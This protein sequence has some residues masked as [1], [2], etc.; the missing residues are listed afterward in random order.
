MSEDEFKLTHLEGPYDNREAANRAVLKILR[1]EGVGPDTVKK[2]WHYFYFPRREDAERA[3]GELAD[4]GFRIEQIDDST[5]GSDI[6]L[7]A[8]IRI[9]LEEE[10]IDSLIDFLEKLAQDYGGKYDGWEVEIRPEEI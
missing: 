8:T 5:T 3:A 10:K 2:I 9:P 6:L 1:E 4:L 7:L